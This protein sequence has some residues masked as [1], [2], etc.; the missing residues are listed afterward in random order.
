M[1][2]GSLLSLLAT[3]ML[4]SPALAAMAPLSVEKLQQ[5]AE[6]IVVAT[7]EHIRAESEPSQF[8][9]R[10]GNADWGIY[11]TLRV[12]E[13]E[14][15]NLAGDQLEARCFRIRYRRSGLEY[16]TVGGHRP[17]PARGTRVRAYLEGGDQAWRVVLPNGIVPLDG[18]A[19][20]APE[21]MQLRGR[22][23]TYIL[24]MEIWVILIVVGVPVFFCVKWIIRRHKKRRISNR[25]VEEQ[26]PD[27]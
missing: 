7:I 21:L 16:F 11:L 18:N 19:G 5:R 23:F 3:A 1:K 26:P 25:E 9:P 10:F 4:H 12:G 2:T 6:V 8:Q 24:P 15:G 20:E 22:E 27:P 13:V 14:K 17:I